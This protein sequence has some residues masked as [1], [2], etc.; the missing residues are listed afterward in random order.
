LS[1]NPIIGVGTRIWIHKNGKV[2]L[3]KRK[4]SL[5]ANTYAPP[6][7]RVEY[8]ETWQQTMEREVLEE[9]GLTIG[10]TVL[11]CVGNDFFENGVHYVTICATA[12]WVAGEPEIRE[13]DTCIDWNWYDWET[14]PKPL[15]LST[16]N[17][18][19]VRKLSE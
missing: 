12:D 8:G 19:R 6:G 10:N 14:L 13:P 17:C 15:F 2:L 5:G 18:E 4:G 16:S 1:S 7:G 9:S 11:C 3:G